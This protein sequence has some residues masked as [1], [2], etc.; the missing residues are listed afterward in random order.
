[1]Q[2]AH[3]P[4]GRSGWMFL[5]RQQNRRRHR[6]ADLRRER[7]VEE[8]VVGAPP[9]RI[10]DDVGAGERRA[11]EPRPVE[12]DVV[13]DPID[14]HVV[15][16]RIGHVQGANLHELGGDAGHAH[17]L[18]ALDERTR[19]R[20][21]HPEEDANFF[22]RLDRRHGN[23]DPASGNR[24]TPL[25]YSE[26]RRLPCARLLR[27]PS[28]RSR[29]PDPGSRF[30]MADMPAPFLSSTASRAWSCATRAGCVES[31]WRSAVRRTARWANG[32]C[33]GRR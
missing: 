31:T 15:G 4:L 10:V 18:D 27:L 8:L 2:V 13:G 29:L 17:R 20:V 1:M 25:L 19:E 7:V 24:G 5:V 23:R 16:A 30:A 32:R 14:D 21:L 12:R 11:L 22:H 3:R 28:V 6:H 26:N 33:P 9:E